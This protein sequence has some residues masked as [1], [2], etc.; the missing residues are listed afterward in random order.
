MHM[1]G[2]MITTIELIDISTTSHSYIV[3]VYGEGS[4]N[5]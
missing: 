4:E 1:K 5:T 2:G 3:T